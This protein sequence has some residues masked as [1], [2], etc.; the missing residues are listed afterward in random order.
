M[1][2]KSTN[3]AEKL[4]RFI[5]AHDKA[6][7]KLQLL[8]SERGRLWS[9]AMRRIDAVKTL[10]ERNGCECQCDHGAEGHEGCDRCLA[11]LIQVELSSD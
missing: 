10:A 7:E 2:T 3:A 4:K 6:M 1:S 11:C 5:D 9:E 8:L